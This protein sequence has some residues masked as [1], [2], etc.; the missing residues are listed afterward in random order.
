MNGLYTYLHH[1]NLQIHSS[2]CL[3]HEMPQQERL[4][5]ICSAFVCLF[6]LMYCLAMAQPNLL[7]GAYWVA[8]ISLKLTALFSLPAPAT[9]GRQCHEMRYGEALVFPQAS[10]DD[11]ETSR[12]LALIPFALSSPWS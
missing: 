3:H 11:W 1:E 10:A 5:S 12:Y 9:T 2:L 6:A 8:H 7:P 4:M